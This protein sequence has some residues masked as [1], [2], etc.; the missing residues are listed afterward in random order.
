MLCTSNFPS[1]GMIFLCADP[2]S[3]QVLLVFSPILMQNLRVIFLWFSFLFSCD[4]LN[5][6]SWWVLLWDNYRLISFWFF[7]K[8]LLRLVGEA[9]L[10]KLGNFQFSRRRILFIFAT[11]FG[12][13]LSDIDGHSW[14]RW[15]PVDNRIDDLITYNHERKKQR[16]YISYN[17]C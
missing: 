11:E 17:I 1:Y 9:A 16:I 12:L 7:F 5:N 6:L 15:S 10:F 8:K 4:F 13:L 3:P 14:Y 2:R